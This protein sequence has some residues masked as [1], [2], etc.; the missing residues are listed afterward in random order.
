MFQFEMNTLSGIFKKK[1]LRAVLHILS[2]SEDE[3]EL[4]YKG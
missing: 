1:Y 2:V 4:Q 3:K